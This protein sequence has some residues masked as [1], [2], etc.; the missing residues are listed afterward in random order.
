M[1]TQHEINEKLR[2]IVAKLSLI[3]ESIKKTTEKL[4]EDG[5]Q[6]TNV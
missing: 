6:T 3:K 5:K 1:Q 2:E 4:K